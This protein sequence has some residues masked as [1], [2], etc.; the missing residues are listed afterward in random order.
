LKIL[1]CRIDGIEA[2]ARGLENR[3]ARAR[4]KIIKLK[5]M[6]Y[7]SSYNNLSSAELD[8][9]VLEEEDYGD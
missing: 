7:S 3:K 9:E 4:L 8:G 6:D 2:K 1:T 5:H